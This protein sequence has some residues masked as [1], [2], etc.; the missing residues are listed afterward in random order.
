ML[1]GYVQPD[2]EIVL[3][4]YPCSICGLSLVQS[5]TATVKDC[6]TARCIFLSNPNTMLVQRLHAIRAQWRG[7]YRAAQA[8]KN[9]T[10]DTP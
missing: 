8:E 9:A 4:I 2:D 3:H 1:F 7:F 10:R 6:T 5:P